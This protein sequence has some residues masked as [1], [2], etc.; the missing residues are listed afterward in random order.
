M[1]WFGVTIGRPLGSAASTQ[2][3]LHMR[4]F[5][6]GDTPIFCTAE[7]ELSFVWMKETGMMQVRLGV[8]FPE[9]VYPQS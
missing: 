7:G 5:F 2:E 8:C 9:L 6:K 4:V 1:A 3:H